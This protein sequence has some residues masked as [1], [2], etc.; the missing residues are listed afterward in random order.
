MLSVTPK[1]MARDKI[2]GRDHRYRSFTEQCMYHTAIL[3][4]S[5]SRIEMGGKGLVGYMF[6]YAKGAKCLDMA[7]CLKPRGA[8]GLVRYIFHMQK[9]QNV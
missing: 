3:T 1:I 8:R 4:S 7:L 6:S 2:M 9:V 5:G